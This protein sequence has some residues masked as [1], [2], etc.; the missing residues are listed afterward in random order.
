MELMNAATLGGNPI[1]Y[2]SI[3][4][5]HGFIIRY[6]KGWSQDHTGVVSTDDKRDY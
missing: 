3:G 6:R 5:P 1:A 2:C 4:E